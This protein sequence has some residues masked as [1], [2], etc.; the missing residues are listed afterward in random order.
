VDE[1]HPL[2][3]FLQLQEVVAI[4]REDTSKD[5]YSMSSELAEHSRIE[6]TYHGLGWHEAWHWLDGGVCTMK[7]IS[8]MGYSGGC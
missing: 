5:L 8:N 3:G 6:M 1:A 7:G 2:D 4:N